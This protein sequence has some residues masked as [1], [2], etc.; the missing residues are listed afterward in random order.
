MIRK[1]LEEFLESV[2]AVGLA[3]LPYLYGH[4]G[5]CCRA[6]QDETLAQA[7]DETQREPDLEE[8]LL[9]GEAPLLCPPQF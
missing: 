9:D 4:G 7:L 3:D 8:L 5:A 1:K 6:C 2:L